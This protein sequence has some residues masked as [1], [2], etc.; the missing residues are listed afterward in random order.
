MIR[1]NIYENARDVNALLECRELKKSFRVR[2]NDIP[3]LKG[4]NLTVAKG[5]II[6]I[7][8]K[9]GAGKSTL[10]S[11]LAGIEYPTAGSVFFEGADLFSFS[12]DNL[13]GLRRQKISVIF[14]NFNLLTTWTAFENIDAGLMFRGLPFI[15]RSSQVN[16]L[17][18][19]LEISGV[20]NNFIGE[21]SAGQQQRVAIARA[22]VGEPVVVLADEPTG[23]V[24][25][26]TARAI[27]NYLVRVVREEKITLVLATHTNPP[28]D[29]ADKTYKLL[30]GLLVPV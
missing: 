5:E 9:S 20:K 26:E 4:L 22:L 2:R 16:T 30:N 14:Q 7:H 8:G 21:L 11:L 6:V 24:D 15:R 29:F 3:V 13:A 28:Y 1:P 10:I 19:A 17:L 23:N 27:I 18:N 25:P 12:S